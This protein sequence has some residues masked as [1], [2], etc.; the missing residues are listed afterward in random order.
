[1]LRPW[2][3]QVWLEHSAGETI[4]SRLVNKLIEDILTGR[5]ETGALLPGSRS[6]AT[7][8][9][10]N[11]KTVQIAYDELIAQGWLV[12]QAKRGTFVSDLLP[13][14][15]LSAQYQHLLTDKPTFDSSNA[16]LLAPIPIAN[17]GYQSDNDGIPDARLIPYELLARAY[18]RALIAASRKQYLGYGD[19]QGTIELRNALQQ[20]L[21][22]ERYLHLT[23]A[24]ICTVRGSQMAIY[25]AS[26]VLKP[27]DGVMVFEELTYGPALAAFA[28]AG[29]T[30]LR[31][32]TD[33]QGLDVTHLQQLIADQ[34][35]AGKKVA[36]IYTTPHHH[37]PTTVTLAMDRRLLL[38]QLSSRHNFYIIE[39]DYDHEF[40]F[41]SRPV[42][43]LAS[44]PGSERVLHIGSLS[45][46]FAPGLR[47]GYLVANTDII[48]QAVQQ[49]LM[50]D[51]Q[52]NTITEL[53]L[54]EL[55][56]SGEVKRHIRKSKKIYKN[57]R[58]HCVHELH[59]L[60]GDSV[61]FFIPAGGLAF[62]LEFGVKQL[63]LA[64]F[65]AAPHFSVDK[66]GCTSIR[67]GFGAYTE[68]EI[69]MALTRL[70]SQVNTAG[71]T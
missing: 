18:R 26:R 57:R 15:R 33:Q 50:I 12:T 36:A 5:L 32:K 64:D 35:S 41:D 62:W 38:L 8:L 23:A 21:T 9:G 52:G 31:C 58:D 70:H 59:R 19:P 40:H 6:L 44:L 20:M 60:F 22:Q 42:P 1:M 13:E 10:L 27:A 55:L 67:F 7:V 25:L 30:I 34:L 39:D 69:T 54:A 17:K 28:D 2:Q 49:I 51:R 48:D 11:R 66:Q 53:A 43:P 24:Q 61:R 16:T 14:Q 3:T 29:F 37:Y 68:P 71:Q 56:A 46:V 4:H 45:K 63:Q 47:V 65:A